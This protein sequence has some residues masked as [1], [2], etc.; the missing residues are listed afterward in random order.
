MI[1]AGDDDATT[2]TRLA[3]RQWMNYIEISM[4]R[5][6]TGA[7][8]LIAVDFI[9]QRFGQ[10]R[11]RLPNFTFRLVH[12]QPLLRQLSEESKFSPPQNRGFIPA[13][14]ICQMNTETQVAQS[15]VLCADGLFMRL[16]VAVWCAS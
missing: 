12:G 1:A 16:S 9:F 2:L 4:T 14:H 10:P 11:S 13:S 5:A 15:G 8:L 3:A 7:V 6:A